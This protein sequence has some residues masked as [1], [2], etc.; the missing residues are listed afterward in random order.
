MLAS[1]C[2][3]NRNLMKINLI[4]FALLSFLAFS[5]SVTP[6]EDPLDVFREVAYNALSAADKAT[7]VGDW[8]D[9]EVSAWTEG[10]YVITFQTQQGP[11]RVVVDPD[12][13]RVVEI[14]P[15]I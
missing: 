13:G 11:L 2:S 9:A 6:D 1:R 4:I 15:R 10:N 3:Q 5:C 7:I 8:R 14:L 12:T